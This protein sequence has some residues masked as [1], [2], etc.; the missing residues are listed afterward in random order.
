LAAEDAQASTS[1]EVRK[2]GGGEEE[3]HIGKE[4][5]SFDASNIL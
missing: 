1:T 3:R 2:R 5:F 4:D